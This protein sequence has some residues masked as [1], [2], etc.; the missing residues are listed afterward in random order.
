MAAIAEGCEEG[1][2]VNYGYDAEQIRFG[3]RINV[4]DER[5]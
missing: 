4:P 1:R 5:K 2:V 3:G